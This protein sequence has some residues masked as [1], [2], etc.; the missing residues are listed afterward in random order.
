MPCEQVKAVSWAQVAVWEH[1]PHCSDS[2]S[3]GRFQHCEHPVKASEA[4]WHRHGIE[5][6]D[7][8]RGTVTFYIVISAEINHLQS[9]MFT[10]FLSRVS[11]VLCSHKLSGASLC[12]FTAQNEPHEA[13]YLPQTMVTLNHGS[14][15]QWRKT[16]TFRG[17]EQKLCPLSC[18]YFC[19][20]IIGEFTVAGKIHGHGQWT[21]GRLKT[22]ETLWSQCADTMHILGQWGEF[23]TH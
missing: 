10:F 11:Q 17:A 9:S 2:V 14:S 16:V 18:L 22:W 8:S 20:W 13:I 19:H 6:R 7:H 21:S 4:G 15:R 1:H 3:P 12:G 23:C 5:Q